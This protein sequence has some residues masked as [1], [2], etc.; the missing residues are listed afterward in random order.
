M[1]SLRRSGFATGAPPHSRGPYTPNRSQS[2]RAKRP[3]RVRVGVLTPH[4]AAKILLQ[5]A[6]NFSGV[7]PAP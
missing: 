6:P 4:I 2:G 7:A 1:I 5:S 3:E